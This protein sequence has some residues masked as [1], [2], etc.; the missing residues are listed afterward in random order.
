MGSIIKR[1]TAKQNS[2]ITQRNSNK[3]STKATSTVARKRPHDINAFSDR[4]SMFWPAELERIFVPSG[5]HKSPEARGT[6]RVGM[7]DTSGEDFN[8][9]VDGEEIPSLLV[10]PSQTSLIPASEPFE[11][12]P[13]THGIA[14]D[15]DIAAILPRDRGKLCDAVLGQILFQ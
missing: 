5:S 3:G 7:L 14:A 1:H 10:D 6:V 15:H 11:I 8:K 13:D 9:L 4:V 12:I 2:P